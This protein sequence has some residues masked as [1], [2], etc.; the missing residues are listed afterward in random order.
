[1]DDE[2]AEDKG[3]ITGWQQDQVLKLQKKETDVG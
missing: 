3:E 2:T 1:L